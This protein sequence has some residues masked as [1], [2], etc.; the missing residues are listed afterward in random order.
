ML[1]DN[2]TA[3]CSVDY[4]LMLNGYSIESEDLP[5]GWR[6]GSIGSYCDVK[7]GLAFKSDWWAAEGYKVVKIANIV[8]NTIDLD[9]SLI[10]I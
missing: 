7:S 5:D 8:N 2:L 10:H 4:A 9:L 1:N 6:Q 3:Q